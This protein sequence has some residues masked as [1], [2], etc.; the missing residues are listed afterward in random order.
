M[1]KIELVYHKQDLNKM[2]LKSY[3]HLILKIIL[4]LLKMILIQMKKIESMCKK[5][6]LAIR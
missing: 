2:N 4:R 3:P 6:K 5:D 1:D